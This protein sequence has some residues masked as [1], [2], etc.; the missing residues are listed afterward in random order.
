MTMRIPAFMT[1]WQDGRLWCT[2]GWF[3]GAAVG[4]GVRKVPLDE[5][6]PMGIVREARAPAVIVDAESIGTGRFGERVVKNMRV[7]GADIWFMT[8][9]ED[10]DDVFDAFNTN[11]DMVLAPYHTIRSDADL[12]DIHSVS[13]SVIPVVF[14]KNS[15]GLVSRRKTGD[16]RDILDRLTDAGFYRTCVLDTDGSVT[17]TMWTDLHDD[18]PSAMPFC[19]YEPSHRT[20]ITTQ[21][22]P[23]DP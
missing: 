2:D 12:E 3:N 19:R 23:F 11:A 10:A 22:S 18:N 13:D 16:V 9:I 5:A 1:V 20:G 21:I 6:T 7:R 17:E 4:K 8:H 15:K 14:V